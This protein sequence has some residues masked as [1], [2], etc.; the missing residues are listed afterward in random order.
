MQRIFFVILIF[1][2]L[3]LTGCAAALSAKKAGHLATVAVNN[4]VIYGPAATH[5]TAGKALAGTFGGIIGALIASAAS[6]AEDQEITDKFKSATHLDV[7]TSDCVK[8]ALQ[9]DPY[10]STR[11]VDNM[12]SADAV[13]DIVIA[14]YGF[15]TYG[16]ASNGAQPI[17]GLLITLTDQSGKQLWKSSR[18]I[19]KQPENQPRYNLAEFLEDMTRYDVAAAALCKELMPQFIDSNGS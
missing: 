12:Q 8:Q 18:A 7:V 13:F 11:L 3:L 4:N 5:N 15:S 19:A 10:W 6:A 14:Q 1:I 17:L 16:V 9:D 2:L